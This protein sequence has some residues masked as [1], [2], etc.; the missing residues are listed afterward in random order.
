MNKNKMEYKILIL[1]DETIGKTQIINRYVN[2]CY[3]ENFLS[4]IGLDSKI[5]TVRMDDGKIIKLQILDTP[6]A[7]RFR[8][9]IS[10]PIKGA[11][12]IILIYDMTNE[13]NFVH[14]DGW[15]RTIR[16]TASSKTPII[17]VGNKKD[18][19]DYRIITKVQ[20]EKFAKENN[21]MFSE[22]SA[23]TG[24][25]VDNIFNILTKAILNPE[26]WRRTI[27]EER[28]KREEEIKRK[29]FEE[30]KLN[31]LKKYISF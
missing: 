15:V 16:N 8:N 25:N 22:C 12:G 3:E 9:F 21:L 11:H 31:I 24:E 2:D 18:C 28:K 17:L 1:G 10:N 27:E 26:I 20:G 7:E 5:K 29:E 19:A 30:K 14:L 4:T 13:Y 23:K 6:G